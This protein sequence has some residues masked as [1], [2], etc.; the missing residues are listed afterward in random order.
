[1][2][3][4]VSWRSCSCHCPVPH[5]PFVGHEVAAANAANAANLVGSGLSGREEGG[6]RANFNSGRIR[7]TELLIRQFPSK[8]PQEPIVRP[9]LV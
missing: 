5:R 3:H 1:V 7:K 4:G 8:L 2:K 6:L 9:I